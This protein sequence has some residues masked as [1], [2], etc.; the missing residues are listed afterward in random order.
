MQGTALAPSSQ[1]TEVAPTGAIVQATCKD[2]V[3][4]EDPE[5][6]QAMLVDVATEEG[7]C[8]VLCVIY[9]P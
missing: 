9:V 1:E 2:H 3:V 4:I 8:A 7:L 6:Q 5:L